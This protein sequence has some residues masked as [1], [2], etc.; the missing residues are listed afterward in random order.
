MSEGP[1]GPDWLQGP[2]GKWYPPVGGVS[3]PGWGTPVDPLQA[4]AAVHRRRP[5]LPQVA[6]ATLAARAAPTAELHTRRVAQRSLTDQVNPVRRL[7][8]GDPSVPAHHP[9]PSVP[10]DREDP[11]TDPAVRARPAARP[12]RD[13]RTSKGRCF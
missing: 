9:A 10:A 11:P 3:D 12:V 7:R 6:E 8:Q 4:A 1:Q 2:D 13:A 5:R